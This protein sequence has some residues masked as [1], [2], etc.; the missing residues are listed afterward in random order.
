MFSEGK[1]IKQCKLICRHSLCSLQ[2][3]NHVSSFAS[4]LLMWSALAP[5]S[6][7]GNLIDGEK[8]PQREFRIK[9]CGG[10]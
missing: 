3:V 1:L 9:G 2:S 8:I 6:Q 5:G 10:D 4:L 7:E